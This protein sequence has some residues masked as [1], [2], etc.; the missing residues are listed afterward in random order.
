MRGVGLLLLLLGCPKPVQ[1]VPPSS[2]EAAVPVDAPAAPD[3][4]AVEAAYQ[5]VSVAYMRGDAAGALA[6]IRSFQAR[7][8]VSPLAGI[9][10]DWEATLAGFGRPAP[11]LAGVRWAGAP[12]TYADHPVTVVVF[13][14][15]WC[16]HC[17]ADVPQIELVRRDFA[18][19]GLGVIGL[20]QLSRGSTDADLATFIERGFLQFPIGVEDGSMTEAWGVKGVPHVA[21]VR[22]GRVEWEGHPE[23]LTVDLFDALVA[24]Q[25]LPL[26]VGE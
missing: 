18:D 24:G 13:F 8:P 5:E 19:R 2:P 16:P 21:L 25:P 4:A 14:E 12:A 26:P 20:T 11:A 10:V 15:P 7:W 1:P 22:G 23:L 6:A 17:Q 3:P 9:F